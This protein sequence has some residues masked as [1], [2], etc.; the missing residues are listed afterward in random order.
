MG[1]WRAEGRGELLLNGD[2]GRAEPSTLRHASTTA[3]PGAEQEHPLVEME[4]LPWLNLQQA[5]QPEVSQV[6]R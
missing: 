2:E 4:A 5:C 6:S 1:P 3:A